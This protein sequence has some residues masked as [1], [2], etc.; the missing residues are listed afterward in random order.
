MSGLDPV[1][2]A[3]PALLALTDLRGGAAADRG[4]LDALNF[5]NTGARRRGELERVLREAGERFAPLDERG[6]DALL[7]GP[8]APDGRPPL[9]PVFYEGFRTAYDVALPLVERA[10]LVAWFAIPTAFVDAPAAAQRRCAHELE[11]ILSR[12][13]APADGRYAMTWDEL[14]DV[15]A[16]GHV[17]VSHTA[18]HRAL[19]QLRTPAVRRRELDGS[20]ERLREMT[21][22]DAGTVVFQWG[23][24]FGRRPAADRAILGAG[25]RRVLSNLAIQRLP[26]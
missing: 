26:S 24:G 16:R 4:R 15:V 19:G 1:E 2:D 12:D 3:V 11:L 25:Y 22:C 23:A 9:L 7:D 20:R 5:H 10:G 8:P 13:P 17:L 14:R 18:T 21:G 6:L